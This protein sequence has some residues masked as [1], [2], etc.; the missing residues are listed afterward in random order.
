[1]NYLTDN[2]RN[3]LASEYVLG[4]LQGPA[5]IRFQ[6]LLMQH[7]NMRQTLWRWEGYLNTLGA[8]LPSQTPPPHVWE[9]IQTRLGFAQTSP[10]TEQTSTVVPFPQR[11]TNTWQWLTGISAAA[12]IVFAVLLFSPTLF[13]PQSS[14]YNQNAQLAVVQGEKAQAL[15][16]IEVNKNNITVQATNKFQPQQDKDYELWVVAKDGRAPVSLG[17]LPKQGKLVLPRADII[18]KV[19]IAALAVSLE[20]LGGSPNGQPTTVLYTADLIAI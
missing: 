8:S 9:N 18:G 4:T 17:L 10:T 16:L 13:V 1:M 12:A 6:R 2:R 5:R 3:A 15:W 11:S 19:E 7:S 14:Q 20:P